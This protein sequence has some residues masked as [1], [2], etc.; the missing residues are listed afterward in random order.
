M[1]REKAMARQVLLG[2]STHD[3]ASIV[4]FADLRTLQREIL[5]SAKKPGAMKLWQ[6][7]CRQRTEV[8]PVPGV[9]CM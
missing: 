7:Y 3:L 4:N 8:Q 2:I 9:A 5:N 6:Y 1:S